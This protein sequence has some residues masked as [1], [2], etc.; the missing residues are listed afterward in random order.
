MKRDVSANL[1]KG[2]N[3][4]FVSD[5]PCVC[6][7]RGNVACVCICASVARVNQALKAMLSTKFVKHFVYLIALQ[8][9]VLNLCPLQAKARRRLDI[10]AVKTVAFT[11]AGIVVCHTPTIVF[12]IFAQQNNHFGNVWFQF[13]AAF[14]PFV[15]SASNPIIYSPRTRKF[16]SSLKQTFKNLSKKARVQEKT[17]QVLERKKKS[18]TIT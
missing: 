7:L 10:H 3:C 9:G 2:F 17:P 16:I 12:A 13:F 6:V 14:S 18:E 11:V 1:E 4:A 15:L 8:R 5:V